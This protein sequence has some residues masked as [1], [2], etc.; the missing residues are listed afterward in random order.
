MEQALQSQ[1]PET[2]QPISALE[3]P[4]TTAGLR[5]IYK[6][7][8]EIAKG[9]IR[10]YRRSALIRQ[11]D[12]DPNT[13]LVY[14]EFGDIDIDPIFGS[15]LV[16]ASHHRHLFPN[17]LKYVEFDDNKYVRITPKNYLDYSSG[18]KRAELLFGNF[19]GFP[20]FIETEIIIRDEHGTI[21]ENENNIV[22]IR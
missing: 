4:K 19:G 15:Y 18:M 14:G 3:L 20:V 10:N 12:F 2:S 21:I 17:N 9:I 6:S 5:T 22:L 11:E 8:W 1:S 13:F 16:E 7:E